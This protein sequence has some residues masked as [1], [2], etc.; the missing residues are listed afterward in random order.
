[1]DDPGPL[2][3]L[4]AAPERYFGDADPAL[5]RLA[6]AAWIPSSEGTPHLDEIIAVLSTDNDEA[7]RSAAAEKLGAVGG[8]RSLAALRGAVADPS[9]TVV[10]AIA[11]A[12]GEIGASESLDWLLETAAGHEDK[13][14]REAALASLGAIGDAVAIP[15]LLDT[16]GSGPPQLR[17]RAV[18]AASVFIDGDRGDEIEAAIIAALDDRNPSVREAAEMVVGR[19]LEGEE[20]LS[21]GGS[22][23]PGCDIA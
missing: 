10:E 21:H 14:V 22:G 17:R 7:V 3:D 19:P 6:I 12:L 16:I 23:G 11:T 8:K 1:M 9:P 20:L 18:V 13:L 4:L 5:R 15:L 2:P